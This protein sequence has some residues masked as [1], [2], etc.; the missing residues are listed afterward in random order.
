MKMV[1]SIMLEERVTDTQFTYNVICEPLIV[2]RREDS[3]YIRSSPTR[4]WSIQEGLK[5]KHAPFFCFNYV[6]R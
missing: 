6:R 3:L 1:R 2:W 5:N 4:E